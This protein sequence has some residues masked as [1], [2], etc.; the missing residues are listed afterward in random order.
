MV[1]VRV[2]LTFLGCWSVAAQDPSREI[3]HPSVVNAGGDYTV[4]CNSD[5]AG[6][7]GK[8]QNLGLIAMCIGW[9]NGIGEMECFARYRAIDRSIYIRKESNTAPSSVRLW[10]SK[11]KGPEKYDHRGVPDRD[12][13]NI[14]MTATKVKRQESGIFCCN[15]SYQDL[16]DDTRFISRCQTITVLSLDTLTLDHHCTKTLPEYRR[17]HIQKLSELNVVSF[18][19]NPKT[20]SQCILD[21]RRDSHTDQTYMVKL[22]EKQFP[23]E[24]DLKRAAY[25]LC[26]KGTTYLSKFASF[27]YKVL[28][29]CEMS[30][31]SD[32]CEIEATS[33]ERLQSLTAAF[34]S[35]NQ[36]DIERHSCKLSLDYMKCIQ[37][38]Y[39]KCNKDFEDFFTYQF[40]RLGPFAAYLRREGCKGVQYFW[41]R[42]CLLEHQF[43]NKLIL[44]D[45]CTSH[46]R[47]T[48][49]ASLVGTGAWSIRTRAW[50]MFAVAFV[51]SVGRVHMLR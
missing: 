8:G 32:Q 13:V 3:V 6:V 40:A 27:D 47:T 44:T 48:N 7:P 26:T 12:S 15:A 39:T 36:A 24:Y 51:N 2:L 9:T 22:F 10:N 4:S 35:N 14:T 42:D 20:Y 46:S 37:A 25:L 18:C 45:K 11:V 23:K 1:L 5:L 21:S 17:G 31:D 34:A 28:I 49:G 41:K 43:Y 38:Q 19:S 30:A 33:A 16:N 29:D 50:L